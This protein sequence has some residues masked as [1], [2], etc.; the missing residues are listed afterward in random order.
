[1]T[2]PMADWLGKWLSESMGRHPAGPGRT[3]TL[4]GNAASLRAN[5]GAP[6]RRAMDAD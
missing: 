6:L 4:S 3:V 1:M 2:A 5:H